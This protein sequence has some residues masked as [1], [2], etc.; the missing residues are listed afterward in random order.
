MCIRDRTKYGV[1]EKYVV[2]DHSTSYVVGFSERDSFV[3]KDA[4]GFLVWEKMMV[5]G[6]DVL[7][8]TNGGVAAVGCCRCSCVTRMKIEIPGFF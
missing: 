8:V 2:R 3:L 5:C 6:D 4:C 7:C 1:S